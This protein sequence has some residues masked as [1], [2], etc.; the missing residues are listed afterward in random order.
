MI[1]QPQ[2]RIWFAA[3]LIWLF[4]LSAIIGMTIGHKEWFLEKTPLN[5]S[6]NL[7]LF[8]WVF[9]VNDV[10]KGLLF[11]LFFAIGMFAE[12]LGVNHGILFGEYAY[13]ENLGPKLD[14]VPWLIGCFWALL[15]FISSAIVSPLKTSVYLKMALAAGLMVLLDYFMEQ[16]A[17]NFDFWT[18][19]GHVPLKNYIT[20]F[21]IGFLMQ[22]FLWKFKIS[23]NKAISAHLYGAQLLFFIYFFLVR[24]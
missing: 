12:W 10:K 6:I 1:A 18:F 19:E 20:W 8:F 11:L 15:A 5:L 2:F 14:G 22:V 23:G 16:N 21:V 17:P 13:G 7:I 24:V 3:F 4:H 9:S